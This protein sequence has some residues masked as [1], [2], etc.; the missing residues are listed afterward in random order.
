M[1]KMGAWK[2]QIKKIIG[3]TNSIFQF[4]VLNHMYVHMQLQACSF[5]SCLN[6]WQTST[7]FGVC[8]TIAAKPRHQMST[9]QRMTS[10]EKAAARPESRLR[11]SS[12]FGAE[13]CCQLQLSRWSTTIQK[14]CSPKGNDPIFGNNLRDVSLNWTCISSG[15]F[16]WTS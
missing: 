2:A 14:E 4:Y 11:V 7:L 10:R 8:R 9:L 13:S 5:V 12:L 16:H 1:G 3:L 15:Y 6:G